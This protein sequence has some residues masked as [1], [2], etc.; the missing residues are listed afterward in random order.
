MEAPTRILPLTD[1]PL[2]MRAKLDRDTELPSSRLL[3]ADILR[4][5]FAR[6]ATEMLD[7]KRAK[8]LRDAE[9]P[10]NSASNTD[11]IPWN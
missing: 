4:L 10:K 1:T 7:A 2:P 5:K 8:D 3:A 6:P 9:L 11:T